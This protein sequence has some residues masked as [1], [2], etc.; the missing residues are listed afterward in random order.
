MR[1]LSLRNVTLFFLVFQQV[2]AFSTKSV[3]VKEPSY[4]WIDEKGE[5]RNVYAYF[6]NE[7]ELKTV[8]DNATIKLY[9]KSLY[10]LY[11][12]GE[13]VNFGPIRSYETNPYYDS[14]N[15][16]PYLK[17]G[18]NIVA[19][20]V[21]TNG[22]HTYQIPMGTAGFIA[23]GNI[24]S[25]VDNI[26][27]AT[28]GSWI[29][30][31][32]MGYNPL[33]P[34][35]S[36]AQGP[37]E[38][39]DA[40]MEPDDWKSATIQPK[41]WKKTTLLKNQQYFGKLAPRTIPLLTNTAFSPKFAVNK[42][43]LSAGEMVYKWSSYYENVENPRDQRGILSYS[44]IY[45]PV[46]QDIEMGF[47]WGKYWINGQLIK[48]TGQP[49]KVFRS[50]ATVRLNKGWNSYFSVQEIIWSN[51]DGMLALPAT[52]NLQF[53]VR[54]KLNDTLRFA[55]TEPIEV[56]KLKAMVT[57]NICPSEPEK[58]KFKWL[59]VS[60][61]EPLYNPAKE[62][63]WLEK[64]K[65]TVNPLKTE[66]IVVPANANQAVVYDFGT[67]HLGRVFLKV[68]APVGTTFDLV[69]SEDLKDSLVT[70]FRRFEINAIARFVS[71]GSGYF[72][73][74]RPY[75]LR[76]LQVNVRNNNTP[77]T[78]NKVGINR[79]VYDFEKT[80]SFS[81]SDPLFN[82][83]WEMGW[84]TLQVCSEDSYTDTPFRERGHYAGD[85]FPEFATTLATSGDPR[86]AK[87]TIRLFNQ[88]Y[89]KT[90]TD[91]APTIHADFPL[92]NLLVASWYIRQFNDK[93]FAQE[94]YPLYANYL[95]M[96]HKS[97]QP[98][99]LYRISRV[100]VEWINLEKTADLTA[101][102]SYIYASF[103]NM[104]V[105]AKIVDKPQDAADYNAMA[106]EIKQFMLAKCWDETAGNF[107]DGFKNGKVLP[108]RHVISSS[109]A[110]VWKIPA[111]VQDKRIQHWFNDALINIGA[112]I[113]RKQLTT[114]YGGFYA[115]A[116]LYQAGNVETAENFIRTHWGK[117]VYEVND[118]TWEDFNR[119]G[120]STLS[121]AWASS[122]TYYMSSQILGVD[123]GFP[124]YAS[125][126][127]I[128][129]RPQSGSVSWAKGT[130][131]H[132]KG[133]VTVDW[134][135]QGNVLFVNYKTPAG[136]PVVVE[137]R[138][139]LAEYKLIKNEK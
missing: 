77:V 65:I 4:V 8:P 67:I 22:I 36:F 109:L 5:G 12:N 121:H 13:F 58:L 20:K 27:L 40:R 31:K 98:N 81:C 21:Q 38:I 59:K 117:M 105:L 37:V 35:F 95:R 2:L 107:V 126:D 78:I 119:D 84:R 26:S 68:D 42:L 76:Y 64:K 51:L 123:L 124:G 101:L 33:S 32:A 28:P 6:R 122:P 62:I 9:A 114:P 94:V 3:I 57:D 85:M 46:E 71:D 129:I 137:P 53:S 113:N 79:Q 99:E 131:P 139:R 133:L 132:P 82:N 75:G 47:S 80:G 63:A 120:K 34:R 96:L 128:Y 88:Q 125:P 66:S 136:V 15:I 115:L 1:L 14:I 61:T 11:V 97:R 118:L 103:S 135:I 112:P 89:S 86:L 18:R 110:S 108:T 92:I 73:T 24:K 39:L 60:G 93:A 74:F 44:F 104:A 48:I 100:F 90:Y 106:N 91:F 134:K 138:G 83:I 43:D 30:R 130:V 7:F 10:N 49:D 127:T 19:V 55:Q 50:N 23:W 116:S 17:S 54:K 29:C 69:W 56:E 52:H 87:H 70:L 72:E 102:Q 111:A 41:L 16:A 25:T 45:S